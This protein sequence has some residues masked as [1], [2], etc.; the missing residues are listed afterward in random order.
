MFDAFD[1]PNYDDDLDQPENAEHNEL[2][3]GYR[4]PS[5]PHR[6]HQAIESAPS[7]PGL[8]AEPPTGDQSP[9]HGRNVRPSSS[10]AGAA[11]HG[12]R[13]SVLRSRVGVQDHRDQNDRVAE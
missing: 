1:A 5:A 8:N 4:S 13:D 10:E 11:Q 12:K 6:L 7:N 9:C 2:M 3:S